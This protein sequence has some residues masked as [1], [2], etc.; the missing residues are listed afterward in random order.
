L[1]T[2]PK[3]LAT[4]H[5]SLVLP[6]QGF[7]FDIKCGALLYTQAGVSTDDCC[8]RKGYLVSALTKAQAR[9]VKVSQPVLDNQAGPTVDRPRCQ[10]AV[11]PVEHPANR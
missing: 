8:N 2:E 11:T 9:E 5:A 4:I 3:A 7:M 1:S 6:R 10:L